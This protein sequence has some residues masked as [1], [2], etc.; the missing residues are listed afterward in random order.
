[1]QS[2][3]GLEVDLPE[4]LEDWYNDE[5]LHEDEEDEEDSEGHDHN[6]TTY[7]LS[8]PAPSVQ[9]HSAAY[10]CPSIPAPLAAYSHPSI[11]APSEQAHLALYSRPLVTAPSARDPSDPS[12]YSHPSI[13]APSA[14]DPLALYSRPL[15]PALSAR[16]PSNP[17]VHPPYQ[18]PTLSGFVGNALPLEGRHLQPIHWSTLSPSSQH[19]Y[20]PYP[21]VSRAG[22]LVRSNQQQQAEAPHVQDIGSQS[23]RRVSSRHLR[24]M[25]TLADSASGSQRIMLE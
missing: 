5:D 6:P 18:L 25:N 14:Q 24:D 9:A 12:A 22:N 4:N 10:P 20:Q 13:P 2:Q 1:M 15:I 17:P 3:L 19:C 16:D 11:P 7:R 8:V 23:L 21:Q